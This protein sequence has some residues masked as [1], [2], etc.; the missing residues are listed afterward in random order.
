MKSGVKSRVKSRV[1][2]RVVLLASSFIAAVS[3]AQA[4]IDAANPETGKAVNKSSG[5][6]SDATFLQ[7]LAAGG[8]AEVDAGKLAATKAND[9]AVKDFAQKMV[10]DHAKT[11]EK[12]KALAVDKQVPLPASV[13]SEHAAEKAKLEKESGAKFDADYMQAQ[14]KNHQKTVQLLQHQI[15][16]GSDAKVRQFAKDTLPTVEHH[17][18]MAKEVHAKVAPAKQ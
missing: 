16:A 2:S 4:P 8:M 12:L 13:D 5:T 18:A 7:Q 1:R 11:N 15:A 14:V 17:L 9:S 3:L 10:V 6:P